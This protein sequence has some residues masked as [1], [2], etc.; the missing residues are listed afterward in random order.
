MRDSS[1]LNW[2]DG[3][4][5]SN[6]NLSQTSI[7]FWYMLLLCGSPCDVS[8]GKLILTS[9]LSCCQNLHYF[10]ESSKWESETDNN[11]GHKSQ[12]AMRLPKV[13]S[14][15]GNKI[16]NSLIMS[17]DF[18]LTQVSHIIKWQIMSRKEVLVRKGLRHYATGRKLMEGSYK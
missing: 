17:Q 4:I 10:A 9:P 2:N 3:K 13:S 14:K 11:K 18:V 8:Y 1:L 5:Y 16:S 6:L 15:F 7:I 12:A